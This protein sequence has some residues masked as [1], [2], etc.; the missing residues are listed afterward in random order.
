MKDGNDMK[1]SNKVNVLET[2]IREQSQVSNPK[3]DTSDLKYFLECIDAFN[4]LKSTDAVINGCPINAIKVTT[5]IANLILPSAVVA[6]PAHVPLCFDY[7]D[8]HDCEPAA[9][10]EFNLERFYGICY[11]IAATQKKQPDFSKTVAEV[12]VPCALM[13]VSEN[14]IIGDGLKFSDNCVRTPIE[15]IIPFYKDYVGSMPLDEY[16]TQMF[17]TLVRSFS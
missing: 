8:R 12:A 1:L 14:V 2:I 16:V 9:G 3:I 13:E 11:R 6:D 15:L 7:K 5:G 4:Y 10:W 17:R